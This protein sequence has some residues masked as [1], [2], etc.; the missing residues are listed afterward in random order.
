[1]TL[2]RNHLRKDST[3]LANKY[4]RDLNIDD[5]RFRDDIAAIQS[6]AT[7]SARNDN[8]MFEFNFRDERYLPF[9]G[10]GAISSWHIKL[11]RDVRQFNFSTITD[12]I[13][14]LDYTAREGGELLRSK[15]I[16]EF[17]SRMNALALAE[18]RRGL[19][20]LFDLRRGYPDKWQKFLRPV[21]AADDQQ[22]V[23]DH[24]TDR[25]PLYTRSFPSK[26]DQGD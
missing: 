8:G 14:H 24:L 12:V 7:S 13:I 25:L 2:A 19:Y 26:K 3:L 20:R 4:E 17:Q 15:A 6:I 22:L 10:A 5:P 23:L 1:L 11:N 21:N 9:E 16:E 18:D